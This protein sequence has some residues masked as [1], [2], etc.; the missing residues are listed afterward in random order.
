MTSLGGQALN[1][2]PFRRSRAGPAE[3]ART[4]VEGAPSLARLARVPSHASVQTAEAISAGVQADALSRGS[5]GEDLADRADDFKDSTQ[6]ALVLSSDICLM[7]NLTTR[8]GGRR[9][10]TVIVPPQGEQIPNGSES[11]ELETSRTNEGSINI[12][13][14]QGAEIPHD[15]TIENN[16][17][18]IAEDDDLEIRP[19]EPSA[20]LAVTRRVQESRFSR[21]SDLPFAASQKG[22]RRFSPLLEGCKNTDFRVIAICHLRRP[23]KVRDRLWFSVSPASFLPSVFILNDFL[24]YILHF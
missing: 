23:K 3:G 24:A 9:G 20:F 5:G 12:A 14:P 7:L 2:D 19:F 6:A 15:E 8:R 17:G 1:E 11:H 21:N 16:E 22:E 13:S 18:R 10:E 4:E